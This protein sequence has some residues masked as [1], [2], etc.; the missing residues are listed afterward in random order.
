MPELILSG[1][2]LPFA[3]VFGGQDG[4]AATESG[5]RTAFPRCSSGKLPVHFGKDLCFCRFALFICYLHVSR[6]EAFAVAAVCTARLS[7]LR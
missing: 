3:A 2:A 6:F 4:L 1:V 5:F 7:A